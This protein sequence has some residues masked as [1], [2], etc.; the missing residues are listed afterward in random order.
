MAT[1]ENK[2]RERHLGTRVEFYIPD[3]EFDAMRRGMEIAKEPNKSAFI[4]SA[5]KSYCD[6][7]TKKSEGGS[8][9]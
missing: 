6:Y 4:R 5:I 3:N 8:R 2:G 1:K 7:L 9:K